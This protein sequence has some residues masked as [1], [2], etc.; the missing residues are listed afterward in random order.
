VTPVKI[1]SDDLSALQGPGWYQVALDG[2]VL[3]FYYRP[4][5]VKKAYVFSPGWINRNTYT[6]PYFQRIK[7]FE[8]LEGVGI[9]LADPLLGEHDDVQIGWF[10]GT[11]RS[12]HSRVTAQFLDSLLK[13]LGV[14]VSSTLF[15]GSSAGGFASLAFATHLRGARAFAVNPQTNILRFHDA[16]ELSKMTR[17]GFETADLVRLERQFIARV[18]IAALW[19]KEQYVPPT[20]LVVNTFD[21]WHMRNHIIPLIG[22]LAIRPLAGNVDVRFFS[23]P[24]AGHNPPGPGVLVPLLRDALT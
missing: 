9:S 21:D 10:V 12:D 7:W 4:S 16:A 14:P 18:N 3:D 2:F 5:T 8:Q 24:E 23:D 13:H 22:S 20:N 11:R 19:K 6:H 15:F 17:A 1:S